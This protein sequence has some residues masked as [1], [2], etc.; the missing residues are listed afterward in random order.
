MAVR[1]KVNMGAINCWM[2]LLLIFS[3]ENVRGDVVTET[4]GQVLRV[5][6]R[7]NPVDIGYIINSDVVVEGVVI[8]PE[9]S[10]DKSTCASNFL[11]LKVTNIYKGD[12]KTNEVID[13]LVFSRP[14]SIE[15]GKKYFVGA[16]QSS[17]MGIDC[18]LGNLAGS[19]VGGR[20]FYETGDYVGLARF[21]NNS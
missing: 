19:I 2:A 21:S 5:S 7:S 9:V 18:P 20:T 6:E 16:Y 13:I 11:K 3:C 8:A 12:V 1:R 10:G 14:A 17:G 15:L 4:K